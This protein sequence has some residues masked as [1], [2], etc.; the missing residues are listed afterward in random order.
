MLSPDRR[1]KKRTV[2]G[3]ITVFAIVRH[4]DLLYVTTHTNISNFFTIYLNII[5][6]SAVGLPSL[7][8][9]FSTK[10]FKEFHISR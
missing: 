4:W 1:I 6:P 7:H 9:G 3:F 5:L 8:S 10:I 2:G